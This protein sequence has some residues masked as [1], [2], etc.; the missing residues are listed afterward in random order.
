MATR[1]FRRRKGVGQHTWHFCSNCKGWPF[2]GFESSQGERSNLCTE[3]QG[4]ERRQMCT[5]EEDRFL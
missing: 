2:E 1:E 3:C 5:T 4:L